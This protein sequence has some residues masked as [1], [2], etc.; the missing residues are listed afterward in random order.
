M[1]LDDEARSS[2]LARIAYLLVDEYQDTNLSQYELVKLLVEESGQFTVV[3]DDDQSIYAWRGAR[4]ENLV[5]LQS[6][7]PALKLIKLE[8]NYRSVG[9]VLNAAN[10]LIANN[11]HVFEKKLWSEHGYGDKIRVVDGRATSTTR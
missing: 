10:H 3:G 7:F 1:L 11:P 4:P 6:D 2:A 5:Q 8:Q 9:A